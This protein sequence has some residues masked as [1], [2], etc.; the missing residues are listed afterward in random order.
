MLHPVPSAVREHICVHP[1]RWTM[2]IVQPPMFWN[3]QTQV[4]WASLVHLLKRS[5][6]FLAGSPFGGTEF[7]ILIRCASF[8]SEGKVSMPIKKGA[9]CC[10]L[11]TV[12]CWET[13]LSAGAS[14]SLIL[15]MT[16]WTTA[17][18]SEASHGCL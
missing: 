8:S 2:L 5:Y 4:F 14:V 12:T 17:C 15:S 18:L 10:K 9:S 7:P 13:S 11:G 3:S 1:P 16:C 6:G